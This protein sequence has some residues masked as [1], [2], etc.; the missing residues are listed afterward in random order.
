MH[1]TPWSRLPAREPAM[2]NYLPLVTLV[3][4]L[5]SLALRSLF[6]L[7]LAPALVTPVSLSGHTMLSILDKTSRGYH[8]CV[9][10]KSLAKPILTA[11]RP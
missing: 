7:L 8:E 5:T 10:V 3:F 6:R 4:L 9:F 2:S 1:V 11:T